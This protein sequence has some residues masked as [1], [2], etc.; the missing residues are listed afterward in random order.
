M[1]VLRVETGAVLDAVDES[2]WRCRAE[3]NA[4]SGQ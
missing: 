3:V 1:G 4:L 2:V